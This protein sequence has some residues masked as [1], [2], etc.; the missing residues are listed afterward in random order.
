[1]IIY[2]VFYYLSIF[3]FTLLL[4]LLS[5]FKFYLILCYICYF[6]LYLCYCI[7]YYLY[8]YLSRVIPWAKN[9]GSRPTVSFFFSFR[10]IWKHVLIFSFLFRLLLFK[11]TCFDFYLTAVLS[12]Y[13]YFIIYRKAHNVFGTP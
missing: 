4:D 1:M 6:I 9:V 2:L 3:I 7:Y 13:L 12:C 10:H 8:Y 5:P 11:K